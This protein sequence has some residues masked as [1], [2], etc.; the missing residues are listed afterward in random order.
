M[1]GWLFRL[2][3]W[4]VVCCFDGDGDVYFMIFLIVVGNNLKLFCSVCSWLGFLVSVSS[5]LV[6]E[7]W[8]VF[9]LVLN[10]RW[11]NRY[12]LVLDSVGVFG[13][14]MVVLVMMDSML[15]VGLVCLL[16]ISFNV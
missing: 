4:D 13:L 7:L 6:M 11:K 5:L 10:S 14:L 3:V 16:V 15:L 8:V 9:V 1:I 12:S 2:I